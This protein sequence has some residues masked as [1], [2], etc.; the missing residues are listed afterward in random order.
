MSVVVTAIELTRNFTSY[1]RMGCAGPR[2][3]T[4]PVSRRRAASAY[5]GHPQRYPPAVRERIR[6]ISSLGTRT[7]RR[8][9]ARTSPSSAVPPPMGHVGSGRLSPRSSAESSD[10]D[11]D[12][13]LI[14]RICHRHPVDPGGGPCE[15]R[16]DPVGPQ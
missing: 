7:A 2:R 3:F 1:Q 8:I 10:P 15:C 6:E 16:S 11:A 13:P 4:S 12:V 5:K 9:T 14:H